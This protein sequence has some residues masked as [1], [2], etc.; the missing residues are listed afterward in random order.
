MTNHH[1]LT[2]AIARLLVRTEKALDRKAIM[3]ESFKGQIALEQRA[4]ICQCEAEA[5][6]DSLFIDP[7]EG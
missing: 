1:E 7:E 6:H 2:G 4:T 5:L 3:A